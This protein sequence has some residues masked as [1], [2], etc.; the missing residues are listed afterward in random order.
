M[1]QR[2]GWL[3]GELFVWR[4]DLWSDALR[5]LGCWLGQFICLMDAAVDYERDRKRH[6]YNVVVAL[7]ETPEQIRET[8]MVLIGRATEVFER[9]PL[10]RDIRLLRNILYAGVWQQ[11]NARLAKQGDKEKL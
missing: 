7:G 1:C 4:E 9:L 5:Q 8:L 11:Y 2:F 3:M 10:E 6:H